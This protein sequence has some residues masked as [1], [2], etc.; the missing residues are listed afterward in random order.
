[1]D[2]PMFPQMDAP[3][4]SPFNV[5][6]LT[7]LIA[8]ND[9]V[10][11]SYMEKCNENERLATDLKSISDS[12][13][14]VRHLYNNEK[15]QKD[16]LHTENV[17]MRAKINLLESR[18]AAVH[19]EKVN[20]ESVYSQTVA[21]FEAKRQKERAEYLD[22]CRIVVDQGN[23][24]QSNSL[25]T[26]QLF[27]KCSSARKILE[28]CGLKCEKVKSPKK[29]P[30]PIR[31][32]TQT[33]GTMTDPIPSEPVAKCDC[34]E[35]NKKSTTTRS[36][37]T[38]FIELENGFT[39]MEYENEKDDSNS[40]PD[41][42]AIREEVE[43]Y[44][45]PISPISDEIV[46]NQAQQ[47]EYCNQETLTTIYNVRKPIDYVRTDSPPAGVMPEKV[48]KEDISSAFG[49]MSNLCWACLSNHPN[50]TPDAGPQLNPNSNISNLLQLMGHFIIALIDPRNNFGTG[51]QTTHQNRRL[52]H[53][54]RN[55][56][57]EHAK[58]SDD[59]P[60]DTINGAS[61]DAMDLDEHSRDSI[62]SYNSGKIVIS[63]V[64]DSSE[65]LSE[66]LSEST[67]GTAFNVDN[68][69]MRKELNTSSAQ[70]PHH[71]ITVTNVASRSEDSIQKEKEKVNNRST[72]PIVS[73]IP[74]IVISSNEIVP[75]GAVA[76][77]FK[78]PKRK[79]LVTQMK[80]SAKKRKSI[81]VCFDSI[82]KYASISDHFIDL[83][84]F[85]VYRKQ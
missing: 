32:E 7:S 22:L 1:M 2:P 67:D 85:S 20:N 34:S 39:T 37:C 76:N 44:P 29:K 54:L 78:V 60:D 55:I 63:K 64:R 66:C 75:H 50:L 25:S 23:I 28:S 45:M 43:S 21:D 19:N 49:S 56:L 51:N 57:N 69:R 77:D 15:A 81:K 42:D 9:S 59:V 13:N 82:L 84:S 70:S 74:K 48:K 53:Q 80:T 36:T 24:L 8:N 83:F 58:G 31:I 71:R 61:N 65:V 41:V 35:K 14:E 33:I 18:L 47:K 38:A 52:E 11:R 10:I 68:N 17:E 40:E 73:S 6:L 79:S 4:L 46:S 30:E 26:E 3:P 62:E 72:S 16:R 12:A 27:R 5:E